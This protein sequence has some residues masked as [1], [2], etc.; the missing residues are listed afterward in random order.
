M[1]LQQ[2]RRLYPS[3]TVCIQHRHSL[4]PT[5]TPL[6]QLLQQHSSGGGT[7]MKRIPATLAVEMVHVECRNDKQQPFTRR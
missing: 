5:Q 3:G 2:K 4:A 6:Q 7:R 1:D